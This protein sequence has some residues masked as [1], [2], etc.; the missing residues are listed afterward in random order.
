MAGLI[1]M[2]EFHVTILVPSTL[3]EADYNAIQRSLNSKRLHE[4]MRAAVRHVLHQYR[5]L[6]R[7]R[8]RLSR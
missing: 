3:R 7:V 4:R 6:L 5:A 1:T 2:D 8:V